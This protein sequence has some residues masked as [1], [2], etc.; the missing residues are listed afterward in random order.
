MQCHILLHPTPVSVRGHMGK[1]TW[2]II[3]LSSTYLPERN[4]NAQ[5]RV[6]IVNKTSKYRNR[7]SH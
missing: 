3:L 2:F 6:K 7:R 4:T 1:V 5:Y